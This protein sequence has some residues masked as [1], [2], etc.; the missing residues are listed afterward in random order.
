V[1]TRVLISGRLRV[2][3]VQKQDGQQF[4]ASELGRKKTDLFLR[5]A[6]VRHNLTI[7]MQKSHV[8]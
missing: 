2:A 3:L 1:I 7:A 5:F 4:S 8:R 6:I